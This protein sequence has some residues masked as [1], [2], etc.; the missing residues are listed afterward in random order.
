MTP[1]DFKSLDERPSSFT[2]TLTKRR[3]SKNS[4]AYAREL[5]NSQVV[6]TFRMIRDRFRPKTDC[7][8]QSTIRHDVGMDGNAHPSLCSNIVRVVGRYMRLDGDFRM[9][10]ISYYYP[11]TSFFFYTGY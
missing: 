11:R 1:P 5:P 6:V 2:H 4:G 8:T 9:L 10:V 3:R 7:A